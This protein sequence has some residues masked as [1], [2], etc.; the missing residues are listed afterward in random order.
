MGTNNMEA[1]NT[2]QVYDKDGNLVAEGNL[3]YIGAKMSV[4]SVYG[5]FDK[6]RIAGTVRIISKISYEEVY[7]AKVVQIEANRIMV[8]GLRNISADLR[9]DLK[10]DYRGKVTLEYT[11]DI[12]GQKVLQIAE[13][14]MENISGGG[15]AF[16]SD[17]QFEVGQIFNLKTTIP[18]LFF[19]I[20]LEV[21]RR[22]NF[23]R[24]HKY[25][26]KFYN[27]SKIEES[28]VRKAVYKLQIDSRN[29]EK[30]KESLLK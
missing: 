12:D 4:F 14:R 22:E 16:V 7:S 8:D 26:C 27:I 10:V 3:D 25:G 23:G 19:E 11:E 9:E 18:D 24:L 5:L 6:P 2:H 28:A 1:K 29:Y 13:G 17:K 30:A 15:I 20:Q 21:L